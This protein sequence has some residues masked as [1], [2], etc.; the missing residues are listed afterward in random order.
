MRNFHNF[1]RVS[2][3]NYRSSLKNKT[4][5]ISKNTNRDRV[6]IKM[7]TTQSFEKFGKIWRLMSISPTKN[8]KSML[9]MEVKI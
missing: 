6:Y 7:K 5:P 1:G 2:H 9:L 8:D 4:H 3:S